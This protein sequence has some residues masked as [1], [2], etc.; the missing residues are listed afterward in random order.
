[1]H[2]VHSVL[3]CWPCIREPLGLKKDGSKE[4]IDEGLVQLKSPQ[5]VAHLSFWLT[6]LFWISSIAMC[7]KWFSE[8][9]MAIMFYTIQKKKLS[10]ITHKCLFHPA[11]VAPS[12]DG[13][14]ERRLPQAIPP[15]RPTNRHHHWLAWNSNFGKLL[16]RGNM[17][18]K[19]LI[20]QI[21]WIER[22]KMCLWE[23]CLSRCQY[24]DIYV[25]YTHQFWRAR[26]LSW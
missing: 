18:R 25:L 24:Y 19:K 2:K 4:K 26:T 9:L 6:K 23:H 15:R 14:E 13:G 7:Y 11:W 17:M 1:M 5:C 22:L 12:G 3:R 21:K 10:I 20:G 8:H 16:W